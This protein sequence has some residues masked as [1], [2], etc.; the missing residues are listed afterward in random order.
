MF[1]NCIET[2]GS[3]VG[4]KEAEYVIWEL[5]YELCINDDLYKGNIKF[6][7]LISIYCA[8]YSCGV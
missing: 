2:F 4:R 5:I 3:I 1:M 7:K 6:Y 8:Q